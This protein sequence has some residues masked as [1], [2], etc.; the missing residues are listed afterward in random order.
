LLS[1]PGGS[2]VAKSSFCDAHTEIS[3]KKGQGLFRNSR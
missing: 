2:P 1:A 3:P